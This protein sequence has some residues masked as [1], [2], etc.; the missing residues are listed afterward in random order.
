MKQIK[1]ENEEQFKGLQEIL[2]Q[3]AQLLYKINIS[4]LRKRD[5]GR[6]Q[7]KCFGFFF[8]K[9]SESVIGMCVDK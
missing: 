8:R 9:K 1:T 4:S 5:S 2:S 3:E 7:R 6:L